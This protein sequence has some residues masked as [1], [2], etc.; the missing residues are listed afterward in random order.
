ME[1]V[2]PSM[3]KGKI[4]G[5]MLVFRLS[6]MAIELWMREENMAA[7]SCFKETSEKFNGCTLVGL[8]TLT[9][10]LC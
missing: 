4:V 7:C 9:I 8:I 1:I 2:F 3:E 10:E 5:S 6:L